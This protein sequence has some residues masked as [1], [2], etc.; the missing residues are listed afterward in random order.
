MSYIKGPWGTCHG[1]MGPGPGPAPP[2]G[3]GPSVSKE[4][5]QDKQHPEKTPFWD[6][7]N[8]FLGNIFEK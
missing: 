2:W 4:I 6:P 1:P 7:E 3:P 8:N 5:S